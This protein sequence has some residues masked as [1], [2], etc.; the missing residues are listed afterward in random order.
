[1][2]NMLR[3]CTAVLAL[4]SSTVWAWSVPIQAPEPGTFELLALGGVVA[5]I[6]AI[7]KRRK[8]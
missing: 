1:M 8:K 5:V 6:V 2:K 7:R 4:V 3:L